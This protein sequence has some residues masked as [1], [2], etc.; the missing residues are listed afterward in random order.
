[1]IARPRRVSWPASLLMPKGTT[2]MLPFTTTSSAARTALVYITL[3]ALLVIWTAV[4]YVYLLNNPPETAWPNYWCCGL[5]MSGVT[6]IGIGLAIG[7]IGK[8]A[9]RADIPTAAIAP[10]VATDVTTGAPVAPV[11]PVQPVVQSPLV[12]NNGQQPVRVR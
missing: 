3:G 6:L 12:A 4:W 7:R 2:P 8:E 5:A 10:T 1:V 11:A 9:R